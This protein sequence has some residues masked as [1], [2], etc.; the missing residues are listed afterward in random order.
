MPFI[1]THG[2]VSDLRDAF[3]ICSMCLITAQSLG[4]SP[5][6]RTSQ[7]QNPI[8]I[9]KNRSLTGH[10]EI[11]TRQK[12]ISIPSQMILSVGNNMVNP[13]IH[14]SR[15]TPDHGNKSSLDTRLSKRGNR[16]KRTGNA[17]ISVSRVGLKLR[18]I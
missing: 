10:G 1:D 7:V 12:V 4:N 6:S 13:L 9:R 5:L 11:V 14:H 3:Y 18:R 2:S 17:M 16:L 15:Y 8:K